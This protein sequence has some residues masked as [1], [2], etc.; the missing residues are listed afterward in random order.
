MGFRKSNSSIDTMAVLLLYLLFSMLVIFTFVAGI[1]AYHSVR[2]RNNNNYA[3]RTTLQYIANKAKAYQSKGAISVGELNGNKALVIKEE[4]D[5]RI[6]NTY[7]YENEGKLYEL[8]IEDNTQVD[9]TWGI[10]INQIN[11]FEPVDLSDGLIMIK[12]G[13]SVPLII[14]VS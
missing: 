14:N 1:K 9:L 2:N 13:S 5:G 12:S 3:L 6:F 4:I 8:F 11:A 7:I 10:E